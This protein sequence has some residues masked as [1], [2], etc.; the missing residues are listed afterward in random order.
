M[1]FKTSPV[2]YEHLHKQ[3]ADFYGEPVGPARHLDA[4]T[5]L[6]CRSP[7]DGKELV[8]WLDGID[9]ANVTIDCFVPYASGLEEKLGDRVCIIVSARAESKIT[10]LILH[11]GW[12]ASGPKHIIPILIALKNCWKSMLSV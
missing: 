2:I 10:P 7:S 8:V 4:L 9:E 12:S 5:H 6:L 1:C 3:I 11:L